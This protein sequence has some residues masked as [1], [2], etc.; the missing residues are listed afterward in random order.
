MSGFISYWRRVKKSFLDFVGSGTIRKVLDPDLFSTPSYTKR[1]ALLT[2]GVVSVAI[3]SKTRFVEWHVTK[4]GWVSYVNDF[5]TS[6]L[7]CNLIVYFPSDVPIK[8]GVVKKISAITPVGK[9]KEKKI[10]KE[11][12][13]KSKV[14]KSV[15]GTRLAK[16]SKGERLL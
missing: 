8:N 11:T 3:S 1:L 10:K 5:P 16:V 6:W 15:E 4:G 9:S 12:G 7:G 14:K 13:K 2:A